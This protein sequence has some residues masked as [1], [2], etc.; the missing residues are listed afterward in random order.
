MVAVA[1]QDAEELAAHLSTDKVR[2]SLPTEAQWEK[3]A[4]GGLISQPYSWGAEPPDPERCDFDHFGDFT[5]GDPR[6]FPAN[7]YGLHGMCGGVWEWTADWY[8]ALA[9]HHRISQG[10]RDDSP[11]RRAAESESETLQRVLRGGSFTDC[12]AA[13]TVSFRMSR[14]ST[15]WR[16][17]AWSQSICP[18]IGFRL[19]RVEATR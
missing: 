12:A 8:D 13:V 9:Y 7:G 6:A 4:R 3:A 18:N 10:H 15:S 11:G 1:W 19:C 2:Y 14:S 5:L 17:A 16:S